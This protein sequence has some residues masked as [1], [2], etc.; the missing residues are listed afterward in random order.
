MITPCGMYMNPSLTGGLKALLL[1]C[2]AQPMLSSKGKA[3]EAPSPLKQV[4][5][6]ISQFFFIWMLPLIPEHGDA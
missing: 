2:S 6:S 4:L 1:G 3:R 5:R